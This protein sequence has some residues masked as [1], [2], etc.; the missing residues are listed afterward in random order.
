[1]R[2]RLGKLHLFMAR[3]LCFT[4]ACLLALAFITGGCKHKAP[5]PVVTGDGYFKTEF[6]TEGEFVVDAIVSDL[7]EQ[8]YFAKFHRLPDQKGFAVVAKENGGTVDAPVYDLQIRLDPKISDVQMA[9]KI[10]GPIW[11]AEIYRP[12]AE[13]LAKAIGLN[14]GPAAKTDDTSLLAK[15]IDGSPDTLEQENQEVSEALQNDFTNP[16]LHEKAALL[17]GMFVLREHSGHFF[18]IRSPLSRLTA[19]LAMAQFLRESDPFRVN[20]QMANVMMLSAINDEAA[21]LE[22]LRSMS[23]NEAPVAAMVRGL[24]AHNTLDY[25]E[26]AAL[27][28]RSPF[29]NIQWF[30][31]TSASLGTTLAWPKL[32]DEQKQ[33]VDFVRIANDLGYSVEIGHQLLDVSGPLEMKEIKSIYQLSHPGQSMPSNIAKVLNET[34][35]HCFQTDS[36]GK[37]SVCVIGWGQ[38]A[39][40]FQRHLCHAVQQNYYFMKSMWGVPDEAKEF[41]ARCDQSFGGLML[42]P[43]VRYFNCSDVDSYHKAVDDGFKLMVKTPQYVSSDCWNYMCWPVSFAPLYLPEANPHLN[44]WHNHNPL[45][46]TVY[47]FGPRLYHPSLTDRSDAMDKFARLRELAPYDYRISGYI[48]KKKYQDKPTFDQAMALYHEILSYS[49]RALRAVARSVYSD[50]TKY[51]ELM[52]QAAEMDPR[53]YYDLADY[54]WQLNSKLNEDKAA[55]YDQKAYDLDPDRVGAAHRAEWL[56]RYW[57]KHGQKAKAVSIAKEAGEVYSFD[58]LVAQAVFYEETGNYNTAFEWFAKIEERYESSTPLLNFCLRYKAKTGDTR[59]EPEVKKRVNKIFPKGME[60]VSIADFKEPP[61]DGVV[62]QENSALLQSAGLKMGDVIVSVYGVRV[63][64]TVQYT[65]ARDLKSTPEMELIV[66]QGDAY[67]EIHASPPN[68]LFG[69]GIG[70][71]VKSTK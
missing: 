13:K 19:H 39:M 62:F 43:F 16:E 21:A 42:Y 1:M 48:V 22:Q 20:G 50:S 58:G 41:A 31:A 69:V 15:L 9:L 53:N 54:E 3:K 17:L 24:R 63:H 2:D 32:T 65:Y 44:E 4:L 29:E 45:P 70:S 30:Y 66:W 56:V 7:A 36:Q 12:V 61:T 25:R 47:D 28:E 67:R 60:K 26:L 23:T 10:D 57:L 51:V 49:P 55:E 68:H 33:T 18:E 35:E 40:F 37:I 27:S 71:Y 64:D 52:T 5:N 14:A 38:W 6:Q 11:S 46:G 34:P 59:F 8:M